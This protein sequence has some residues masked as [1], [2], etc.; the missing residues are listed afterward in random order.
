MTS[1]VSSRPVPAAPGI[2]Y[3][4]LRRGTLMATPITLLVPVA[5]A[6]ALDWAG[7]DLS[8]GAVGLGAAGWLVALVSRMPVV[9][10]LTRLLGDQER[11]KPWVIGSSGP[12]EEGIRL[13]VLLLVGRSFG[14]AAS[15]GLGWAAIE[16]VY[17]TLTGFITLSLV[18]R[19]DAEAMQA[20]ALLEAQGMLRETGPA[21]GVLERIGA[22]ALHIGFT[23]LISWR[24]PLAIL[25][26]VLH[27]AVNLTLVRTFAKAPL[28][29]EMA[30]LVLGFA[31]LLLGIGALR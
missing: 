3:N 31:A 21:L 22:S 4:R 26:A 25:T 29:T 9:L 28:V 12:L 20:R 30:L 15:I 23:L 18:R 13:V 27:S 11:V 5:F 17:T 8:V 7:A 24:L 6:V 16:V 10:L 14:E 19:T 1:G 2:D